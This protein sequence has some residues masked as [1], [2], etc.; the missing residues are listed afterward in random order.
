MASETDD[1]QIADTIRGQLGDA[2]GV[3]QVLVRGDAL[4]LHVTDAFYRRLAG[5]RERA[6]KIVL[7]LMQQ[8][9][10][11]TNLQDVTVRVYCQKEQMI[12]GKP[13]AWGGDN[14]TYMNDL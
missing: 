3:E 14:V 10:T 8:M 1:Q 11:L 9:R 4:Q 12:E 6:R 7:A 13:K 5:D 2:A